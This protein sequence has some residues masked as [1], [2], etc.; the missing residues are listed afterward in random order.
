MPT[1]KKNKIKAASSQNTDFESAFAGLKEIF[2]RHAD[3]LTVL[4]DKPGN[5]TL[6]VKSVTHK[7]KPLWF[8]AVQIMK[9]YV[10]FHLMPVYMN[11]AL[12]KQISP[13]LK[14]RMQG[15]ACFNFTAPDEKL[16]GELAELTASGMKHFSTLKS[17]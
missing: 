5:Y 8:G 3:K 15:K 12:Q 4:T 10:S 2:Q 16:F 1:A 14:K 17:S 6:L 11:P 13:E 7:G 9:N